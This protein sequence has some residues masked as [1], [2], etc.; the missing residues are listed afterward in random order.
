M[1]ICEQ[2]E[3]H[4]NVECENQTTRRFPAWK[5]LGSTAIVAVDSTK[6]TLHPLSGTLIWM[7]ES[8]RFRSS[9]AEL[10][11]IAQRACAHE[12]CPAIVGAAATV[13]THERE[14]ESERERGV[15]DTIRTRGGRR[16]W[17]HR[18]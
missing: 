4:F 7:L 6:C 10:G 3:Q 12:L 18:R 1:T 5:H 11:G 16:E 14:K 15:E 2:T 13:T 8:V 17:R 9:K